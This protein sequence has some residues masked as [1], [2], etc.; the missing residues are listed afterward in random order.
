MSRINVQVRLRPVRFAFLVQ[1]DDK[2]RT[3]EIFRLA[4]SLWGGRFNPIVPCFTD[5]PSWWDRH[6]HRFETAAQIVNGYL[7]FFEPDFIVEAEPGLADGLGFDKERVLDLSSLLMREGD[8]ARE[9]HGQSVL[10]LYEDL[11]RKEY[12]FTRRH[13]HG[14]I[15]VTAKEAAFAEFCGCIFGAFPTDADLEYLSRAF[16]D[17]FEP[18]DV[19]LDGA[20]LAN[21]YVSG[22]TSVLRLGMSKI[23]VQYHDHNDPTIFVL[24]AEQSRDLIDFWNLRAIRGNVVPVPVQWLEDLSAFCK[25]F[26][27]KN[28]RPLPGNSHGVMIKPTVMFSRSIST[29]DI[30]RLHGKHIHV[31][32]AGANVLQTWYPAIWRPSPSFTFRVM[33]PTLSA[34]EKTYDIPFVA[35]KPEIRFD[36]LAPDF[37]EQYGNQHRWANVVRLRD[38][39]FKDQIARAYPCD[40]RDPTFIKFALGSETILPTTEG[41]VIFPRYRNI[42][43]LWKIP[44]GATAIKDW[45]KT[46]GITAVLSDAGRVTQQIIQTVGGFHGVRSFASADIVKLLNEM[47]RR[48]VARSAHHQE[49]RNRIQSAT[50]DDVWR[51]RNFESLVERNVVELGLELKCSK[52]SSWSWYSLKQLDYQVTCTLCLR[53]FGF[54]ILDP[55]SSSHSKWAYRL[56]G[57]FALPNYAN[58]GYAASLSMRFFAEV[59]GGGHDNEVTWS[60]GLQLKLAPHDEVEV[61]FILWYQRKEILRND[62][63]TELVFGEAKSF[64]GENRGERN[65]IKDIFQ[66]IDAERLKKLAVRFPGSILVFATM[67]KAEEFSVDEITRIAALAEWGREYI[68]ERRQS[69]A[70]VI[71]LTGTELFA[72]YSIHEAWEKVDG[73]HAEIAKSGWIRTENLRVLADLTQQLYLHMPSY[74]EWSEEKWRNRERESATKQPPAEGSEKS[75]SVQ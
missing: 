18:R 63:P 7:D 51:R 49:F 40:Y 35:E 15:S 19:L 41:F 56:I 3:L 72:P 11:Y 46:H 34:E 25:D 53:Q 47:S 24:D 52:C 36:C 16:R 42:P 26:I 38:W 2:K 37:A 60:P 70:P 29:I 5:V 55:S 54:P 74:S 6:D 59:M 13:K 71:V 68:S 30:E 22:F 62:Y 31:D 39:S 57:P 9:G 61:D 21:L 1:P 64:G 75:T 12:Q 44:D 58:G 27:V 32:T 17:A 33:R 8:R 23:D 14:I 4:S 48:S 28:Y 73:R 43:E 20:A 69:R 10:S 67:K 66:D 50:K 65:A 45:L